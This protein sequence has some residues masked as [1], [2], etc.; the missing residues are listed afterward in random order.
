MKI[1]TAKKIHGILETHH[2]QTLEEILTA[3]EEDL[4]IADSKDILQGLSYGF[5]SNPFF[6]TSEVKG[7]LKLHETFV[8]S[9]VTKFFPRGWEEP[10]EDDLDL[11]DI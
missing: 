4:T 7:P 9:L 5:T 6:K 2:N 10:G 3:I 11:A 8:F 1:D